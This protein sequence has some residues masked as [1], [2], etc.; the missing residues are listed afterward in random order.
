MSALD[1]LRN[2]PLRRKFT[3]F[4]VLT[5]AVALIVS[6]VGVVVWDQYEFRRKLP[7]ELRGLAGIVGTNVQSALDF[8]DTEAALKTLANLGTERGI[9]SAVVY[10]GAGRPFAHYARDAHAARQIPVRAGPDGHAFVGDQLEVNVPIRRGSELLG[11]VYLKSELTA[12]TERLRAV[13]GIMGAVLVGTVLVSIVLSSVVLGLVT[14]PILRLAGVARDV[15]THQDYSVR[16]EPHGN[17]EVGTL[18]TAF[19]GMLDEIQKRDDALT[20]ARENLERRVGERTLALTMEI[21]ERERT[22]AQLRVA[23]DEAEAAARAKS[24]FLATM[25]HEIRT[26]MNGVLGMTEL[27]LDTEL[28]SRQREYVLAIQQSGESLLTIINDILDFSKVEAGKFDIENVEFDL[29][30]VVGDAVDLFARKAAE[31][32]ITL[33]STVAPAARRMVGGDPTRVR[34]I[35]LNLVGNAI[36]FTARGEVSIDTTVQED[37]GTSM[38]VRIAVRDTGIGVDADTVARLF[39]PFTQA[40][41]STSRKYG[42]TGL[43]LAISRKLTELMGGEVGVESASGQGST[44][45][46]TVRVR[47]VDAAGGAPRVADAAPPAATEAR[48]SQ[49]SN[50]DGSA[51][52]VL[53]A[54]AH[55]A[56]AEEAQ[57]HTRD[58]VRNSFLGTRVL[59]ADDNDINQ[60]VARSFLDTLGCAVVVVPT[61]AD[62][63][64]AARER[65]FDII[66]MDCQMPEMDGYDAT[67]V[68]RAERSH[69]ARRIPIVALTASAID[70]ERERCLSAGMD[71]YLSKP[72]R[73]DELFVVFR[74]WCGQ[75]EQ[76][77]TDAPLALGRGAWQESGTTS[78][79]WNDIVGE[80]RPPRNAAPAN[81]RMHR[82]L[83]QGSALDVGS[84]RRESD[85]AT[86]P[87]QRRTS[88]RW[89]RQSAPQLLQAL[90]DSVVADDR[91]AV[92]GLA[93]EFQR[94]SA[95][96]GATQLAGLLRTMERLVELV[97]IEELELRCAEVELA[98]EAAER[99]L[100][101]VEAGE[102]E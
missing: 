30:R 15:S 8:N 36:K 48:G 9:V 42:G 83:G 41:S 95:H 77:V 78:S 58:V 5:A 13:V 44:F 51:A 29:P 101:A 67:R 89:Y 33:R 50:L 49:A 20:D 87:S 3:A 94:S 18:I 96:V 19:N 2:Q 24:E 98:Y 12:L 81:E 56:T 92:R 23:K 60:F 10:D 39:E 90:R 7:Q 35:I 37:D 88:I 73:L 71:D 17:D 57:L 72:F 22:E 34:Q 80:E 11:S 28:S 31:K 61:G 43:G 76:G 38:L 1:H 75:L 64:E 102:R 93:H 100:D 52:P 55:E 97:S 91:Q 84:L 47:R 16:A 68:I 59:L 14:E 69:E 40:D 45:W 32:Q 6:S 54:L 74:R 82:I 85:S 21:T 70:G 53:H 27:M 63:V 99:E 25:S 86:A 62:A 79:V 65:D 4:I 66:L 46:F 26:P